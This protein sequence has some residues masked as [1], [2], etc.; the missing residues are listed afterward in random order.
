VTSEGKPLTYTLVFCFSS[1]HSAFCVAASLAFLE[2]SFSLSMMSSPLRFLPLPPSF[3][4][5]GPAFALLPDASSSG[6]AA[7]VVESSS[8]Y[9]CSGVMM[10]EHRLCKCCFS[11]VKHTDP[12]CEKW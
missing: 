12:A 8:S 4:L 11:Y 10:T 9:R 1:N 5:L 7:A 6:A 3:V 2:R